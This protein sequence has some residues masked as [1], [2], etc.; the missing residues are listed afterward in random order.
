MITFK[1]TPKKLKRK[2]K[3]IK[4]ILSNSKKMMNASRGKTDVV[5]NIN[6]SQED[7]VLLF[8]PDNLPLGYRFSP[9]DTELLVYLTRKI[10]HQPLPPNNIAQV[11]LY[12]HHPEQ[13]AGIFSILIL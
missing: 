8:D 6:G 2:L 5:K 10:H 1:V 3:L 7:G 4:I 13:L 9:T 11:N 12:A